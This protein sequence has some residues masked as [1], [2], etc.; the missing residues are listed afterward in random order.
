MSKKYKYWTKIQFPDNFC[1]SGVDFDYDTE[2]HCEEYGCS[3]DG[4]CRCSTI[5]NIEVKNIDINEIYSTVID[6][7][8]KLRVDLNFKQDEEFINYCVYRLLVINKV[9]ET[10]SWEVSTCRGYYGEEIDKVQFCDSNTISKQ[11]DTLYNVSAQER[12]R[13]ILE[14]EYG[15]VLESFKGKKFVEK[16]IS[17]DDIF[18]G[19]DSYRKKVESGLYK[20]YPKDLPIGIY[21]KDGEK[22]RLIDGYHRFI[23]LAQ[24]QKTV[25]IISAE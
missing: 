22:Y 11:I 1:Y 14:M 20:E 13:R 5:E 2:R 9:Y 12:I 4:I 25:K 17:V 3:E 18:V 8:Q 19:N 6:S 21:L 15:F 7:G 16:E 24:K 10:S 23:D